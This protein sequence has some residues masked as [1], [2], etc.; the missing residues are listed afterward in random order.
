MGQIG[1]CVTEAGLR[2]LQA[3]GNA[4]FFWMRQKWGHQS[5]WNKFR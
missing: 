4:I 1:F 3:S 2:I 5:A